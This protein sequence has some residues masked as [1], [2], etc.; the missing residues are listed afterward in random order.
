M[1][2]QRWKQGYDGEWIQPQTPGYKIG[3]CD[4]GLVHKLEFRIVKGH[5]QIC[6]TRDNRATASKRRSK[7]FKKKNGRIVV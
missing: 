5:I 3:C 4:C 2:R 6:A 7:K 1:K